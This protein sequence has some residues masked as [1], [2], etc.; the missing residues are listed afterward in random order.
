MYGSLERVPDKVKF[1]VI[2]L[3]HVFD[4]LSSSLKYLKDKLEEC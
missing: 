1:Y 3:F 4:H 2:S